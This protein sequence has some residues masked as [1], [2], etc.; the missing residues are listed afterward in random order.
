MVR[1]APAIRAKSALPLTLTLATANRV[2]ILIFKHRRD[3][4]DAR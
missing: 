3:R 1:Y 4:T 2:A